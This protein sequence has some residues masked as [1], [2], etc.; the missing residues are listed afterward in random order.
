M[1]TLF[2]ITLVLYLQRRA[3][4]IVYPTLLYAEVLAEADVV[5]LLDPRQDIQ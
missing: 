5:S 1:H 2:G 4:R 3:F